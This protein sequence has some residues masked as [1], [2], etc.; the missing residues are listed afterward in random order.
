M[1]FS[2]KKNQAISHSNHPVAI[3][4][5][6]DL[7]K[8]FE[9]HRSRVFRA[10]RKSDKKR[11]IL[12]IL[13]EEF[14]ERSEV[15]RYK[16]QYTILSE[17]QLHC[18]PQ[19]LAHSK[20]NNSPMLVFEDTGYGSLRSVLDADG[21][22]FSECLE[23]ALLLLDCLIEIHEKGIIHKDINPSN[24]LYGRD[25]NKVMLIDF[26]ISTKL[27][28]EQ[29]AD[30]PD[31][32]TEGSLPYMSPEQTGRINRYVDSRS[33]L[34]SFGIVL[35]EL[36]SGAV[37]FESD[38]PLQL[39]HYHIAKEP[40]ALS[41]ID[42]R[43]PKVVSDIV[44]K[45]LSKDADERYQSAWGVKAD[46]VKCQ[47][48][49]AQNHF[50]KTFPLGLRDFS[51]SLKIP[52]ALYGR[53]RE[54]QT[55]T[56]NLEIVKSGGK[57]CVLLHGYPG[58]GK[59]ALI[60]E[61]QKQVSHLGH[62][63]ISG[64]YQSLRRS[65]PYSGVIEALN[66]FAIQILGMPEYAVNEWKARLLDHLG[67]NCS[68]LTD[69][70][71]KFKDVLGALPVA[72][73]LPPSERENR[74]I[75]T[76]KK[77]F[78]IITATD[79]LLVLHL[80]DLQWVDM[81][82]LKLLESILVDPSLQGL[83]F[84]GSYR[85]KDVPPTHPLSQ[86]S[87]RLKHDSVSVR[88]L[89][90]FPLN[91][92]DVNQ[93]VAD[94]LHTSPSE[95]ID[96][97]TL[98]YS[99]TGGNPLFT[100]EL[101]E[102]LYSSKLLVLDRSCG[103]WS[104]NTD[105]IK[106]AN[107]SD[108][109]VDLLSGKIYQ[110]SDKTF[111]IIQLST[112]IGST[113]DIQTLSQLAGADI[114]DV[115][116]CLHEAIQSGLII[117]IGEQYRFVELGFDLSQSEGQIEYRFAHERIMQ[118]AGDLL[119][120]H[121]RKKLQLKVARIML[122]DRSRKAD[123]FT[124]VGHLNDCIDLIRSQAD[125]YQLL[126]LNLEAARKAKS[127]AAYNVAFDYVYKAYQVVVDNDW[128]E[129]KSL[130]IDYCRE[131]CELA[132]LVRKPDE[133]KFFGQLVLDHSTDL[134]EQIPIYETFVQHAMACNDMQTAVSKGKDI[135]GRLGVKISDSP[136]LLQIVWGFIKCHIK[137]LG[138]SPEDILNLPIMTDKQNLAKIHFQYSLTQCIF[139]YLPKQVPLSICSSV[140]LTLNH[141]SSATSALVFTSYGIMLASIFGAYDKGYAFGQLGLRL[142]DKMGQS[143]SKAAIIV[144]FSLYIRPWKDPIR[145]TLSSLIDAHQSGFQSG[146]IEYSVHAAMGYCYRSFQ[147]GVDLNTV[148]QDMIRFSEALAPLNYEG[149]SYIMD[150][151]RQVVTNLLSW[152]EEKNREPWRIKGSF[153]DDD[154]YLVL[155]R[156][157]G[158]A[159]GVFL[160]YSLKM[161]LAY[162]FDQNKL[163]I[164]WGRTAKR[165]F[166]A[167]FGTYNATVFYFYYALSLLK[168][169]RENP[170]SKHR[171][172][173][174]EIKRIMKDFKKWS[175]GCYS[176]YGHRY[177]LLR[178][179]Y[180]RFLGQSFKAQQLYDEAVASAKLHQFHQ[181][182]ALTNELAAK[183]HLHEGRHT[184]ATAY[185]K[186]A[187]YS[188]Q[189]WGSQTKVAHLES[190]YPHLINSP[191]DRAVTSSLATMS[192][193]T[194]DITTLKKA[195][196]AIAEEA[197]HSQMLEKIIMSAIEFAGA[198][199]GVLCLKKEGA[200]FV[201]AS[202]SVD[203]ERPNIL[204]SIP[205]EQAEDV[206]IPV[207]NYVR[208][209]SKAL[210]ID[211][212][213]QNN[214]LIPGLEYDRYISDHHVKSI[215]CI[216][217]VINGNHG[218]DMVGL[219]YLENNRSVAAFTM[220][221]IETLE[222]ICLSAA[223]RLELS[224]KA[225]TDGLTGLYNHD[226]FQ[227][228]LEKEII[229][230]QRQLRNLA[231]V[232]ID[233]DHF[234]AFND[235]WGHQVGDM[236]LKHVAKLIKEACRKSDIV[237]RYGGE[238]LVVILPETEIERAEMVAERMRSMI[239][240]TPLIHN[241]HHLRVTASIGLSSLRDEVR[242]AKTLI[243]SA[244]MALYE[245]KEHGRNQV[246]RYQP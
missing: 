233:I 33:D 168:H 92:G 123:V 54:V 197:I 135:L 153:Y 241:G 81:S 56:E 147:A 120:T 164:E 3:A 183:F 185:M 192:S 73:E 58:V 15:L 37:P 163:A 84:L 134:I 2:L 174:R 7:E 101:L 229:Q 74:F 239:E 44:T 59:T 180:H 19:V 165:E 133:L 104:W 76:M 129:N 80:D 97:S 240:Q 16:N 91:E 230:S 112:C 219:L 122:A 64:Q 188:Y 103:Q 193:S 144:P 125:R 1:A 166:K 94:T 39:I 182:E 17:S 196:L 162:M 28:K 189:R 108:N 136:N 222:I 32:L 228:M 203:S 78:S 43:I 67:T 170:S 126:E 149:S 51:D 42:S 237:A 121:D 110:L 227:S 148:E 119:A 77:F 9:S 238:E 155:H 95:T 23:I 36:L 114:R 184:M 157:N 195:L 21:V 22:K 212:A 14:L 140:L 41:E 106:V 231:L 181:D 99:K 53:K 60:R 200:F 211:D 69:L 118:A 161:S 85:E 38:D 46:L 87:L 208:R 65:V 226:Y 127:S 220:E 89:E 83:Y 216:P 75:L 218:Q 18:T 90:L 102:N 12:K 235:K 154:E 138:Q 63:F 61:L 190:E 152:K 25:S 202:S 242:T 186:R 26:G 243:Q 31:M 48:C 198:Q 50:I 225:A 62:L 20:L 57:V 145:D 98:I 105:E 130:L 141:G 71:P 199:R 47:E 55:L 5:Y 128:S 207:I 82:S 213:S 6:S 217:I 158:D 49:Y 175:R 45:L 146:N 179:E 244:D 124:I 66:E 177:L 40:T 205:L 93:L 224:V 151:Y 100:Q 156:K 236:V 209:T 96:L 88:E 30:N 68:V 150:L 52:Q 201:D 232:M 111:K 132:F 35:Y 13:Q 178:A 109:V 34:Y 107:L 139:L 169:I 86:L 194:I 4:G 214:K 24:I 246:T 173:S 245:S 70:V 29:A 172:I 8:L 27:S 159:A 137:L 210:V 206:C 221:R 113:F 204:Q 143:E 191:A 131:C 79:K 187:R 72:Q 176:N 115:A 223:G 116:Q 234:K 117:P 171:S 142:L 215:L 11:V 167:G 160:T 10:I